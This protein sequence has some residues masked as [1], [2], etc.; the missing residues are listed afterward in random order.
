MLPQSTERS[1]K[2]CKERLT[3]RL[4]K[5]NGMFKEEDMKKLKKVVITC[6]HDSEMYE[7]QF[8][9]E[10]EGGEKKKRVTWLDK[11]MLC[12]KQQYKLPYHDLTICKQQLRRIPLARNVCHEKG[13]INWIVGNEDFAHEVLNILNLLKEWTIMATKELKVNLNAAVT[14]PHVCA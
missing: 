14:E 12:S 11:F 6:N 4:Y 10:S 8:I 1:I 5:R 9:A 2:S 7:R 3:A 13:G